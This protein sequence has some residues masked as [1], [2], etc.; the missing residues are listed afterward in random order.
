MALAVPTVAGAAN[1]V[2]LLDVR[3][4]RAV[5]FALPW[6]ALLGWL[7]PSLGYPF[8]A[9]ATVGAALAVLPP[10]LRERAM[11]GDAGSTLLGFL[12]GVGLVSALSKPWLAVALALIVVEHILAET[13][14]LS[15]L[16]DAV[17]PLRWYDRAGRVRPV[18]TTPP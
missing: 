17:P 13:V 6:V 10:D 16:I 12:L 8:I 15:R 4:G 1:G 5:K 11:L 18:Q 3:P 2:N 9:A 14:T 7:A